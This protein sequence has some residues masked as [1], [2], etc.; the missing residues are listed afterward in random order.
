MPQAKVFC[1]P[2]SCCLSA[3]RKVEEQSL[4]TSKFW[5]A[6]QGKNFPHTH[7]PKEKSTIKNY[8]DQIIRK[9]YS[10]NFCWNGIW[11]KTE[12]ATLCK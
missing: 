5:Q 11:F 1:S 7:F 10:S 9:I 2:V 8:F 4:V 6:V 12:L 3:K